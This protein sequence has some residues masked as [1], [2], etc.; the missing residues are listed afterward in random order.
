M[1]LS[2]TNKTNLTKDGL[3]LPAS[4]PN[5]IC[6]LDAWKNG[7][8]PDQDQSHRQPERLNY[9]LLSGIAPDGSFEETSANHIETFD[10]LCSL[11]AWNE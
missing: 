10:L 8:R 4:E 11:C 9:T 1:K 7:K 2:E 5:P 3:H 6:P